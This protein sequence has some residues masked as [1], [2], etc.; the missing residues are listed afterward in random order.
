MAKGCRAISSMSASQME[1]PKTASGVRAMTSRMASGL[2]FP[3]GTRTTLSVTL[4]FSATTA[5]ASI[6]LGGIPKCFIPA[7]MTHS[8]VDDT[9]QTSQ[10]VSCRRKT[11]SFISGKNPL[12]HF[13]LEKLFRGAHHI[14]F[15]K[16]AIH[17]HHFGAHVVFAD[18][19]GQVVGV[20]GP[21]PANHLVRDQA[22]VQFPLEKT[23]PGVA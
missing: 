13:C 23:E 22:A 15:R 12:H 8:L 1:F 18:L 7:R 20:A 10:P 21:G 2:P 17:G 9:A 3:L 16:P 19:A 14:G 11:R 5:A 4:P 6:R